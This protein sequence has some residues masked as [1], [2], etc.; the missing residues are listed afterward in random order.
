MAVKEGRCCL[1]GRTGSILLEDR[2]S[3]IC[4]PSLGLSLVEVWEVGHRG[5]TRLQEGPVR[6]P[7]NHEH[8]GAHP[9]A[10]QE[11]KRGLHSHSRGKHGILMQKNN[12]FPYKPRKSKI[13][14]N[15]NHPVFTEFPGECSGF[16]VYIQGEWTILATESCMNGSEFQPL[17]NTLAK[18]A[19]HE[20]AL[21]VSLPQRR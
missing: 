17:G 14:R 3:L 2:G 7:E 5:A 12:V 4:Q 18:A 19:A 20:Q 13:K 11:E 16:P 9:G 8:V 15:Q 1:H 21:S 6:P 10:S